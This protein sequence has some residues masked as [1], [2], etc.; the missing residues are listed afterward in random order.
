MAST[1]TP[2]PN[3]L[4]LTEKE[5]TLR[6]LLLD[7]ADFIEQTPPKES[8]TQVPLPQELQDAKLELRFTGGW[9]RDKLLGVD[10]HDIDVAINKMTGYQFGLRMKD[11]LEMPQ[12]AKKHGVTSKDGG[13]HKIEAN[14]EKSKHLETVTTKILGLD[15]DLVNLRKEEYT[16]DSR[17][18][19]IEFGTP[20]E[21]AIRRDATVNAMFYNLTTSKIEDFTGKGFDDMEKKIIRTPMEP[22]QTFKD[23]PLRV[24]RLIRFA[25]RLG[26]EI[27]QTAQQSMNNSDIKAALEMKISRE[28]VG[29]ELEKMLRGPDPRRALEYIYNLDLFGTIF[30]DPTRKVDFKPEMENWAKLY[31]VLAD[32]A[33]STGS[34]AL[35]YILDR[36]TYSPDDKY[37]MWLSCALVPWFSAPA[38]PLEKKK[39]P[40]PYATLVAREGFKA[41]NKISDIFTAAISHMDEIKAMARAVYGGSNKKNTQKEPGQ[42]DPTARDSIGMAIRRWGP[43]WKNQVMAVVA[44]EIFDD[45]EAAKLYQS[46]LQRI[47]DLGV[48]EA[49]NLKPLIDGKTLSKHFSAPPGPWMKP[50]LDVVMAWQLRNPDATAPDGAISDVKAYLEKEGELTSSLIDHMLKLTIRAKFVRSPQ[51]PSVTAAGRINTGGEQSRR[52]QNLLDEEEKPWKS[53]PE[54]LS[55]LKWVVENLSPKSVELHWPLLVPPILALTDD[56]EIKYKAIGCSLLQKLLEVTPPPLLHRTGLAK[57]FEESLLPC[58]T[59]LPT[60][61]PEAESVEI[62]S[63][64]FPALLQLV[65]TQFPAASLSGDQN[66]PPP[67]EFSR[68]KARALDNILRTGI[69][70]AYAHAGEHVRI[71]S[72]LLTHLRSITEELGIESVRH[73]K[74][75]LPLLCRILSDPFGTAYMPLLVAATKAMRTVTWEGRERIRWWRSQVL[76]GLA[77][78]WILVRAQETSGHV[79]KGDFAALKEEL[80]DEL[81]KTAGVLRE[82]VKQSKMDEDV[83]EGADFEVELGRL[84]ENEPVIRGL[85][86]GDDAQ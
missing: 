46:L 58:L 72:V 39:S 9:V 64:A 26:Y 74:D 42:D 2:R 31:N 32:P 45:L 53:A 36:L 44:Y 20:E 61:T 84:L 33:S 8:E 25:T 71:A 82:V 23:D 30:T 67:N 3:T 80:K 27:E 78:C 6:Q 51:N 29:I 17:N 1:T 86:A 75:V 85:F 55:L 15:I 43:T 16:D 69:F 48:G 49:Y 24:L 4:E 79:D 50:A 38:L 19:Q 68:T 76:S 65:R 57:V 10:S 77:N 63:A 41:P 5:T 52:Q 7:V 47:E 18:P 81:R 22:Y 56:Y 28:R 12:N 14:P 73:L 34:S 59:Y 11:Y 66:Q 13:L 21:D 40:P 60:L 37:F 83:D 35:E 70:T 62:L 54:V